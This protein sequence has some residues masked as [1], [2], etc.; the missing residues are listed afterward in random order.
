MKIDVKALRKALL[1]V[2]RPARYVGGEF[3]Q[4]VKAPESVRVRVA[5]AFPDLYEI[6]AAYLGFKILYEKINDHPHLS[7]E[8][9]YAPWVDF[10]AALREN[11]L[12]LYSLE[13]KSSL[14]EFDIIGFTL[15]AEVNYTNVVN[16]L[17]LAGLPIRACDRTAALPLVIAGGEGA[18]APEPM[19]RF[20]DAFLLGD[21]EELLIEVADAVDAFKQ[22]GGGTR[23]ELLRRLAAIEGVYVPETVSFEYG[24]D[25]RIVALRDADGGVPA[26]LRR[27]VWNIGRDHGAT[28]PFVPNMR[29]VHDRLVVEIRR[30]CARGCRFCRAGMVNRPV[31][32]R[33]V[34]EVRRSVMAGLAQTG[35]DDVSLLSLSSTD[36][37]CVHELVST[38]V[39][40]L[41]PRNVAVSLP[42]LRI[43]SFDIRLADQ[44]MRVRKTGITF[45]P[46]A[47]TERL[48]AVINKDITDEA[49]LEAARQVFASG[50]STLK[51]YF[52]IGL[53]TEC[54][55]DLEGIAE[56]ARKIEQ[57]GFAIWRK[58]LKVNVTLSPFVPKPHTPFQWAEQISV[59]EM[60]RRVTLVRNRLGR[61]RCVDLKQSD[62]PSA[63]FEAALA[64]GDRRVGAA[65]E[66]A[67]RQGA[68][69][70]GWSDRFDMGRWEAAFA[71]VGQNM[72]WHGARPRELDEILPWDHVNPGLGRGFLEKEWR[73]AMAETMTEDC[74]QGQCAGCQACAPEAGH[75]LTGPGKEVPP[76]PPA[77]PASPP[78]AAP[79]SG[80]RKREPDHRNQPATSRILLR[81]SRLGDMAYISHL[82]MANVI[83]ATALRATLPLAYSSGFHPHPQITLPPAI[84]LGYEAEDEPLEMGLTAPMEA[85]QVRRLLNAAS[86]DGLRFVTARAERP[87]G[88]SFSGRMIAADYEV[89][90]PGGLFTAEAFAGALAAFHSRPE[91]VIT[92]KT[93]RGTRTIDLK[94]SLH[95]SV[96]EPTA[97]QML[98]SLSPEKYVDPLM[99]LSAIIG[100][101]TRLGDCVRVS[102]KRILE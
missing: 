18:L 87:D 71:S 25:G 68:R 95:L 28:R 40:E 42:S 20:I 85:D 90:L 47:G 73:L 53:P 60:R 35:Y 83:I 102:R 66:A 69:F 7:A 80:G 4:V 82:D 81:F 26:P 45:A 1:E 32:E 86:P 65:I 37:T 31:R 6:G 24:A 52:M 84:P 36:H 50:W 76:P 17:D 67:W 94:Q 78:P 79:R 61:C 74:S 13:T 41:A 19:S 70:D 54:D 3:N 11:R 64:R 101:E 29:G 57:M 22:S 38:L 92:K 100:H 98:I 51:L 9:V 72:T 15:Q 91:F 10:E 96:F 27:R 77:Q 14:D 93:K 5:L 56:L 62:C 59:D 88:P 34:S 2:E 97:V 48:R 63:L 30:G 16:M 21:G 33:S 89:I 12:P 43:N 44:I 23:D 58:R 75:V 46:E 49:V 99:A 8:R 39:S 55:E